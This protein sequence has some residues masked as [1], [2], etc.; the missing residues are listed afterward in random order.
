MGYSKNIFPEMRETF[1]KLFIYER[2]IYQLSNENSYRRINFTGQQ[3]GHEHKVIIAYIATSFKIWDDCLHYKIDLFV[4]LVL[5][6]I[7]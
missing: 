1:F 2:F 3:M 4:L 6:F 7:M 5:L